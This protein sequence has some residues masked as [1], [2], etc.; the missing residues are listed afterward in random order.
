MLRRLAIAGLAAL[1]FV[2]SVARAQGE[3]RSALMPGVT[4]SRQVDFTPHGP[5]VVHVLTAPRPGG[6]YALK[7]VLSNELIAG[8]ETVTAIERR[9]SGGA[10]VVGVNG[11]Y[12]NDRD[13]HP[14]GVLMRNGVLDSPPLASRSSIAIPADGGLRVERVGY[15]GFWKGTG[16]RRPLGFNQLPGAGGVSLFTPTFGATTPGFGDSSELVIGSFPAARPNVELSGVVTQAKRGGNTPIPPNGAVLVGRGAGAQSLAAEAPPGIA[17]T[18]RL[19]FDVDWRDVVDAIGGGPVLV[20]GGRPIFRA[21]EALSN[22]QL[23]SRTS[24]TAVGQRADGRILLVTVDGG[25]A[26]YSVGMTNLELALTMM[27]LGCVTAS[28]LG[29]G[30]AT[31]LAF[32]G[33]L[34]NRPAVGGERAVADA[35]LVE[36]FGVYVP[37][38]AEEVVSPNGDGV[39]DRQTLAYKVIRP[40]TVSATLVGPDGGTAVIDA[41][42]RAAG[43]YRF[44]WT[45]ARPDGS[46]LPEGKWRFVVNATDDQG[47]Q[48]SADRV[49]TL[50]Q[51]LASLT[52]TPPTPV[53]RRRGAALTA[54]CTL[55]RPARVTVTVETPSGGVVRRLLRAD[56]P[57]GPLTVA[58]NGRRTGGGLASGGRYVFHVSAT[59]EL[60]T[61]DLRK[62]F[63]ARR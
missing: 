16:Q 62:P 40:S 24:R 12:F 33:K 60:G 17:V 48:S 31:A 53:L 8:R 26:G 42:R 2:P 54:T 27:R 51:T 39:S 37:R 25:R 44:Q 50:N 1:A 10:T 36:Y 4:Y 13:G 3:D 46:V 19:T 32:D 63:T 11:D 22:A 28:A 56:E 43:S 29:P 30:P 6:L 23:A 7:P 59:N 34:L 35:L 57:A 5:V 18:V 15:F 9:I 52:L 21:G 45:G 47:R 41:G 38:L 55:A 20:R 58:W 14:I 49:F 61:V